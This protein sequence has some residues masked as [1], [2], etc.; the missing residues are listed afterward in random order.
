MASASSFRRIESF[1]VMRERSFKDYADNPKSSASDAEKANRNA[2]DAVDFQDA[3]LSVNGNIILSSLT[4]RCPPGQLTILAG[5]VGCGKSTLLSSILGEVDIL[6]GSIDVRPSHGMAYCPQ[7]PFIRTSHSI[8]DN[9]TFMSPYDSVLYNKVVRACALHVDLAGFEEGD[10]RIAQGLSGGERARVALARAL[11]AKPAILLLDDPLC[12]V[13]PVTEEYCFHALFGPTGILRGT[14]V[15]LAS[16]DIK[17]FR[18]ADHLLYMAKQTI[19]AEGRFDYLWQ[20]SSGFKALASSTTL[21]QAALEHVDPTHQIDQVAQ[22]P[23]GIAGGKGGA[24]LEASESF[25]ASP[26]PAMLRYFKAVGLHHILA[27]MVSG[28]CAWP[29]F[30]V[31][32]LLLI[33][34]GW[35]EHPTEDWTF[36]GS[37]IGMTVFYQASREL[38]LQVKSYIF[39]L[40]G[41]IWWLY[42]Q[43]LSVRR[44]CGRLHRYELHGFLNASSSIF[45]KYSG[46]FFLNRFSTDIFMLENE[47]SKGIV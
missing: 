13:D 43:I 22:I 46:G 27:M 1:L 9:I 36:V 31:G 4:A 5:S 30:Q 20:N 44:A 32:F 17:R 11:Y 37:L 38:P 14:T 41:G 2:S 7:D 16:N 19:A 39:Q 12:A 35:V 23:D 6:S 18:Q 40:F 15:I 29:L 21:R 8:R 3:T 34:V 25:S 28:L 45:T 42:N 10:L 26:F 47:F 24:D 33:A